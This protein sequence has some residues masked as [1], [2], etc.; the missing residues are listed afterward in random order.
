M[1]IIGWVTLA[2]GSITL[3]IKIGVFALGLGLAAI[4]I[5]VATILLC[6]WLDEYLICQPCT[7]SCFWNCK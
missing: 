6:I 3:G 1:K 4:P 7:L 2:V 5:F